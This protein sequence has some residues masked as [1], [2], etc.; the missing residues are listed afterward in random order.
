MKNARTVEK[1]ELLHVQQPAAKG[2]AKKAPAA[3]KGKAKTVKAKPKGKKGKSDDDSEGSL[4]DFV[5]DDDEIE[6]V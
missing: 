5:A 1:F 4:V 6:Y 2:K 3:V